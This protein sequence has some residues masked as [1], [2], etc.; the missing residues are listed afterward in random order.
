[1]ESLRTAAVLTMLAATIPAASVAQGQLGPQPSL[2]P[3]LVPSLV[4]LKRKAQ[5][6]DIRRVQALGPG[7]YAAEIRSKQ[8]KDPRGLAAQ[9]FADTHLRRRKL[10]PTT[11]TLLFKN[12]APDAA[13][14]YHARFRQLH[15]GMPVVGG[16]LIVHL[17][18]QG[19][20]AGYTSGLIPNLGLTPGSA[21]SRERARQIAVAKLN[22]YGKS[23]QLHSLELAVVP[24]WTEVVRGTNRPVPKARSSTPGLL[25]SVTEPFDPM[26]SQRML[27]AVQLHWRAVG[28]AGSRPDIRMRRVSIDAVTGAVR[29]DVDLQ[30]GGSGQGVYT[31]DVQ[32]NS[33][34]TSDNEFELIDLDRNY[35]T[36]SN[37]IERRTT[38]GT[39]FDEDDFVTDANDRWGDGMAFDMKS[40]VATVARLQ[41]AL[42]DGHYFARVY[43][44]MLD[45][46]FDRKGPDGNGAGVNVNMHHPIRH[47]FDGSE[48]H[49]QD[50]KIYTIDCIGHELAHALNE[51]TVNFDGGIQ[52]AFSESNSDF[53]G[54][55]MEAYWR[56]G[57]WE[58]R[59]SEIT[60]PAV[61]LATDCTGRAP[62]N[63]TGRQ[64]SSWYPGIYEDHDENKDYYFVSTVNTRALYF[65]V[66]GASSRMVDT[67]Y[68][69]YLPW[70][71]SGIGLHRTAKLWFEAL[72]TRFLSSDDF[73]QLRNRLVA[74]A[75]QRHGPQSNEAQ[76]ASFAYKGVNVGA[77]DASYPAPPPVLN[78]LSTNRTRE[79]AQPLPS[80]S[81]RSVWDSQVKLGVFGQ[82]NREAWFKV[83]VHPDLPLIARLDAMGSDQRAYGLEMYAADGT[84]IGSHYA[85]AGE[86]DLLT[87]QAPA[88]GFAYVRVVPTPSAKPGSQF[89]L[90]VDLPTRKADNGVTGSPTPSA[91]RKIRIAGTLIMN[92]H[93]NNAEDEPATRTISMDIV[94]DPASPSKTT[95]I[96][97]CIGGEIRVAIDLAFDLNP[98]ESVVKVQV[99]GRLY[100]GTSCDSGDLEQ[101]LSME[102]ITIAPQ[103]GQRVQFRMWNED[104]DD[105]LDRAH[106]DLMIL[107]GE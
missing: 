7:Q 55:A 49:F 37:S 106:V 22:T 12:G 88:D 46:V 27:K 81:G 90:D 98:A 77:Y 80:G 72:T 78:S 21:V 54:E 26:K 73:P 45:K 23:P 61:N 48:V 89:V 14:G 34:K 83:D 85:G 5:L 18:S 13:G 15:K 59:D 68:S 56:S 19:Q 28:H 62:L 2:D 52:Q 31:G 50:K 1:M 97:R 44:D 33:I 100:E 104:E 4:E 38:Q 47:M 51:Y 35:R 74:V 107:N 40:E 3:S 8:A 87:Y 32:L 29:E 79:T 91:S 24:Q 76:A 17:S 9:P 30:R 103:T 84:P 93:E 57:N 10:D 86:F 75:G 20:L 6:Q 63:P 102:P 53:F 16:E 99:K 69:P 58:R 39:T 101:S 92:D 25:R 42:V 95:L 67:N 82:G 105:Q 64:K 41:S 65:L 11:T 60:D 66:R 43:W 96:R 71:M 94:L 36:A 70:G